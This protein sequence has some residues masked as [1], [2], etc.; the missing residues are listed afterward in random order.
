MLLCLI[1]EKSILGS[2]THFRGGVLVKRFRA[3]A[4][5]QQLVLEAFE[6]E[7]WPPRVDDPLPMHS[8]RA[9]KRAL[10]DTIHSLNARQHNPLLRFSGD[11]SGEGVRWRLV[12]TEDIVLK[13]DDLES[14][15]Q[16]QSPESV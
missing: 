1:P 14:S 7:G 5:N 3:P 15:L 16:E 4:P 11:G 12:D 8:E 6:E 10:H 9:P 2:R 13:Q